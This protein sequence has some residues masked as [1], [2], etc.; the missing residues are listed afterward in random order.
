MLHIIA[1]A[2]ETNGAIQYPCRLSEASGAAAHD[3]ALTH[4]LSVE[5]RTIKCEVD[6]EV[7][8]VKGTLRC[9]HALK[10]LLKVLAR[11]VGGERD[12][13]LDPCDFETNVSK[14]TRKTPCCS[15]AE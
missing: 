9:V 2:T 14:K 6:V 15:K 8:A 1:S 11:K 13:F 3:F 5:L 4:Q 12:D 10:V 7:D